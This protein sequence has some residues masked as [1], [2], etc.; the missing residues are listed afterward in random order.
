MPPV[1][2]DMERLRQE[3]QIYSDLAKTLT[4]TLDL[5]EVLQIIMNKV[6]TLLKPKT[7]RS[8][9]WRTTA[10]TCA[11]EIAVGRVQG[12]LKGGASG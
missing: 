7:G 12:A 2:T 5:S 6:K 4:S 3:H 11:F 9:L 10:F 1:G 8:S